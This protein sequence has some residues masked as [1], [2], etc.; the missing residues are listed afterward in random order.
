MHFWCGVSAIAGA[1]R[2]K[3]WVDMGYFKWHC[4]M[5]II[6]V[7]PPGI[8]SKSTTAG[9]AMELLRNVPGIKFGP[10]VVTWQSLVTSFAAASESFE[11]DGMWY[12]MCAMT[13]ESSEFGN[14]LNPHDRE[15]VDLL[16]SLWD[17]KQ[18]SFIK[19]TKMSGRDVIENP[20]INLLA[21]TTPAWIAGNFPDYMIGGGFTSRCVFV[22]AENKSKLV[23][24]PHLHMPK[25]ISV[26]KAKLIED[27]EHIAIS[28]AGPFTLPPETIRW[29]TEW[30][31]R[32]YASKPEH[33]DDEK[34]GGYLARK[35]TMMHKL[36]LIISVA[37][38][39]SQIILPEDLS[40]AAEMLTNLEPDMVKVFEKIGKTETSIQA[41][42]F[43]EF[44]RKRGKVAYEEAY[45]Y[46]HASFPDV[47]D[48]EGIVQGAIRAGYIRLLTSPT[49]FIMEFIK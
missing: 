45:R 33:L 21:C 34:F 12:P 16:V 1:L 48:F 40:V 30:Y 22:Y 3:V 24:Y 27:L 5:Y 25:D 23:A 10:D 43:I 6:L 39:D 17:G 41:D 44:V 11:Y 2:R 26:V 13:L 28:F 19:E 7:A 49:G 29:G 47:K 14:L 20:W 32:H 35:Q 15:M 8:V 4:N 36:A 31:E 37:N 9:L 18:G 38:R 46:I 42:R